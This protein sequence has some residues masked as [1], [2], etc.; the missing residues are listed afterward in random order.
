MYCAKCGVRLADSEQSC[1][2][3]G[4]RAYH[5]DLAREIGE[6]PYPSTESEP[7]RVNR[8]LVM[9]I[10]TIVLAI[11]AL[12]LVTFDLRFTGT[13]SWSYYAAGG[14]VC[15]YFILLFPC[16]FRRAHPV[17]LTPVC[18]AVIALYVLGVDLLTQGGW[19]LPFAFPI[20]GS[21]ALIVCT[22]VTLLRYT[23]RGVFYITGGA[24]IALGVL[25][26]L[27]ENLI[28]VVFHTP[29]RFVFWSLYPLTSLFLL[30]ML[31]IVIGIVSPLRERLKKKFFI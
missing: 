6:P 29:D 3:C 25:L 19:F 17:I 10:V 31:F 18:F 8:S 14:I 15:L 4:T 13:L 1:P 5:P 27:L 12:Q 20:L 11:V 23:P 16:W 26:A 2:L 22:V 7:K 21:T 24:L 30:G 28:F 9:M